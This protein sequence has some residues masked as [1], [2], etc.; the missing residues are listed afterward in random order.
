MVELIFFTW[1]ESERKF[2]LG[3]ASALLNWFLVF[4]RVGETVIRVYC[5]HVYRHENEYGWRIGEIKSP[6][7]IN[8]IIPHVRLENTHP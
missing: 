1:T 4:I 3:I 8:Q 5:V 7:H 6:Y 2:V